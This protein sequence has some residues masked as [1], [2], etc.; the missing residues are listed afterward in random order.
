MKLNEHVDKI[1]TLIN[2]SFDNQ[3]SRLGVGAGKMA[4]L[5]QIPENLHGKRIKID[6]LIET[7]I[8]RA[9]V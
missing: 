4:E 2:K 9:H 7:Q 5:N 3:F 6:Q 8:G 1:R